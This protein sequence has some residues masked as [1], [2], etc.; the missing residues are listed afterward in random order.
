MYVIVNYDWWQKYPK[1]FNDFDTAFVVHQAADPQA[2]IEYWG[3]N[4]REVVFDPEW[5]KSY[6]KG[7]LS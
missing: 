4:G 7:E 5:E 6:E 3:D 2:I 1:T